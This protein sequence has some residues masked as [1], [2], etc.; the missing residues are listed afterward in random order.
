VAGS[1]R[2]LAGEESIAGC[3]RSARRVRRAFGLERL[4][5]TLGRILGPLTALWILQA[6]NHSYRT[7][8]F[9]RCC[10]E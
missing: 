7:V 6:T 9:G 10:Q 1:R 3:G 2:S 4:M 5:D 8:F